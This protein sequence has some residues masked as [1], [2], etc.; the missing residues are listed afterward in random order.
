MRKR[1]ICPYASSVVAVAFALVLATA[2]VARADKGVKGSSCYFLAPS[3]EAALKKGE[4]EA[5]QAGFTEAIDWTLQNCDKKKTDKRFL[6][7]NYMGRAEARTLL[8]E[9]DEAA[10]DIAQM[11]QEPR[12]LRRKVISGDWQWMQRALDKAIAQNPK[13]VSLHETRAELFE[14]HARQIHIGPTAPKAAEAKKKLYREQLKDRTALIE[15]AASKEEKA[16]RLYRRANVYEFGLK[17]REPALKDL[18]EAVEL[19]PTSAKLAQRRKE[20]R[21]KMGFSVLKTRKN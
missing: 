12:V 18:D 17:E 19:D 6:F 8:G 4:Y 13:S 15:L 5:A 2:V 9:N 3:A 11:L 16:Q 20:L 21:A 10:Q 14:Q 1:G 7:E